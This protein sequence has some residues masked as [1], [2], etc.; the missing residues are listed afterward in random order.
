MGFRDGGS[1]GGSGGENNN[2]TAIEA[3]TANEN[4]GDTGGRILAQ[5]LL[6]AA[7]LQNGKVV[8]PRLMLEAMD[9]PEFVADS[10]SY[11][12]NNNQKKDNDN[13]NGNDDNMVLLQSFNDLND[14]FR[15]ESATDDERLLLLQQ[16]QQQQNFHKNLDGFCRQR[17]PREANDDNEDDA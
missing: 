17:Q 9:V 13:D 14:A 8:H 16:Q 10:L 2:N 4:N 5:V 6:E 7:V 15:K 1:G 11:N 3:A 12:N